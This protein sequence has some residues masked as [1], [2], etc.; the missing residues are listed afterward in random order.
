MTPFVIKRRKRSLRQILSKI[1]HKLRMQQQIARK[2]NLN[3]P[4]N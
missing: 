1:C 4:W 3:L 2:H